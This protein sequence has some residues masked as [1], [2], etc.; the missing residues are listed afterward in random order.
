MASVGR[1]LEVRRREIA[2]ELSPPLCDNK[3]TPHFRR[4]RRRK[5]ELYST[6]NRNTA[7]TANMMKDLEL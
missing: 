2:E 7:P 5:S 3:V 6:G 1:R 4:K